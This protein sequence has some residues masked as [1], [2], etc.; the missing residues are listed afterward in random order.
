[1]NYTEADEGEIIRHFR[2]AV[3]ILREILDTPAPPSLKD[4]IHKTIT[5]INRDIVNAENQLKII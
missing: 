4:K 1:M 2:M 5:L 3:Q